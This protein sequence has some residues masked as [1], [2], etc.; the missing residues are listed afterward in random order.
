MTGN[1]KRKGFGIGMTLPWA[2]FVWLWSNWLLVAVLAMGVLAT[3]GIVVTTNVK[4]AHWEDDLQASK[5]LVASL[6]AETAKAHQRIAELNNETARLRSTDVLNATASRRLLVA[7]EVVARAAYG[8][9]VSG[10]LGAAEFMEIVLKTEP[11]AGEEFDAIATTGSKE[12]DELRRSIT[13]ALVGAGWVEVPYREQPGL[14]L[15]LVRGVAIHVDASKDTR[16]LEAAE[17]LASALNAG[18]LVATVTPK[19]ESDATSTTMIHL[20]IGPEP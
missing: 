9:V 6:Q 18:G 16:H 1:K 3:Y 2:E 20:L 14:D 10:R 12:L 15:A 19:A 13:P 4:E 8:P 17:A 7:I 11:F 5:E